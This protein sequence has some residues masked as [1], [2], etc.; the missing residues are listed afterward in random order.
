MRL[1]AFHLLFFMLFIEVIVFLVFILSSASI[2][3]CY[4]SK[5]LSFTLQ[6]QQFSPF[7]SI[8]NFIDVVAIFTTANFQVQTHIFLA[9]SSSVG[10]ERY[11]E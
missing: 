9:S 6:L 11:N 5:S 4:H 7:S 3:K 8:T 1:L 2:A 10:R